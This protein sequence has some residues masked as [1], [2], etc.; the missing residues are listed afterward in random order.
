MGL[1]HV[2]RIQG[3]KDSRVQVFKSKIFENPG[4]LEPLTSRT[5]LLF[6]LILF[7]YLQCLFQHQ[8]EFD[9]FNANFHERNIIG[10][11]LFQF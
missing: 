6:L 1:L 10:P 8:Q 2:I 7:L 5:Q 9:V 11:D 4:I 3:A